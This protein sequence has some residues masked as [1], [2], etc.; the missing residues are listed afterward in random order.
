VIRR[1]RARL[2]ALVPLFALLVFLVPHG[3]T[4]RAEAFEPAVPWVPFQDVRRS[5]DI[6]AGPD[7]GGTAHW[8]LNFTGS[9]GSAGDTWMSVYADPEPRP[10]RS[11]LHRLDDAAYV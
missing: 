3:F 10:S 11:L 2:C 1:R 9:T 7:L 8:A 4:L 6:D 5:G